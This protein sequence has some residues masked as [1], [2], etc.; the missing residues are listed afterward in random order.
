M[1]WSSEPSAIIICGLV[2]GAIH[3]DRTAAFQFMVSRPIVAGPLIGWLLGEVH[4]GLLVGILMELLWINYLPMGSF[5]PPNETFAAIVAS[6]TVCLCSSR[7]GTTV[8]EMVM[9]GVLLAVPMAY[10]GRYL[11]ILVRRCNVILTKRADQAASGKGSIGRIVRLHF[12][13]LLT[14]YGVFSIAIIFFLIL[15]VEAVTAIYPVLSPG[16][17]ITLRLLYALFPMLGFAVLLTM[18]KEKKSLVLFFVLCLVFIG[19]KGTFGF[20]QG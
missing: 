7:I 18:H 16:V 14:F 11:D 8:R 2:G 13:G 12:M 20:T 17:L 9:F 4:V 3:L 5:I 19:V 10:V 6:G 1:E 15:Y